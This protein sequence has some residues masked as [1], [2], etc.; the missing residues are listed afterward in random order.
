MLRLASPRCMRGRY[1]VVR[2]AL[3]LL[4]LLL[5]LVPAA[6]SQTITQLF[7]PDP[8]HEDGFGGAVAIDGDVVITS[9]PGFDFQPLATYEGAGAAY[10]FRHDGADWVFEQTLRESDSERGGAFGSSIALDGDVALIGKPRDKDNGTNA[11]AAYLFRLDGTTWVEEQKLVPDDPAINDLSGIRV[12][13]DGNV[14]VVARDYNRGR[15]G[16]YVFRYD[17]T[18]WTLEQQLIATAAT[19][20]LRMGS[21]VAVSG[22]VVVIGSVTYNLN[23]QTPGAAFVFRY[24]G[25]TWVEE[26]VLQ[27][28]DAQAN[29]FFGSSVSV[30]GDL[31]AVGA[32]GVRGEGDFNTGAIYTFRFD[33][34]AWSQEGKLLDPSIRVN[35]AALGSNVSLDGDLLAAGVPQLAFQTGRMFVYRL[36]GGTWQEEVAYTPPDVMINDYFGISISISGRRVA[37]GEAYAQRGSTTPDVGTFFIYELATGTAAEPSPGETTSPVLHGLYPNPFVDRVTLMV[38]SSPAEARTIGIYDMLGRRVD[39][40]VVPPGLGRRDVRWDAAGRAPGLYLFRMEAGTSPEHAV[41][42]LTR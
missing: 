15:G 5:F 10:V 37:I 7:S 12:A 30:D 16:A 29:D 22:D 18:S 36:T 14:A 27:A 32:S 23:A 41:G 3:L 35:G 40:I 34:T 39:T 9:S 33:G 42:I 28:G 20:D 1:P 11:G 13:I 4:V 2:R 8:Q 31:L 38:R 17:G 25:S 21:S 19:S 26:Q 6:S 24:D